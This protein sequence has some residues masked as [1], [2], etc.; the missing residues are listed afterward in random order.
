MLLMTKY[1]FTCLLILIFAISCRNTPIPKRFEGEYMQYSTTYNYGPIPAC[2]VQNATCECWDT[3]ISRDTFIV[4]VKEQEIENE[5]NIISIGGQLF[6]FSDVKKGEYHYY[7]YMPYHWSQDPHVKSGEA[8]I[9][10]KQFFCTD[11]SK[12]LP[13]WDSIAYQG[14]IL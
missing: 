14:I 7:R 9:K 2:C 12:L 6:T 4:E 11:V 10:D 5:E 1:L 3:L 8:Y 13:Y